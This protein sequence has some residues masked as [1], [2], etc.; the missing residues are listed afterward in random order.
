MTI[1]KIIYKKVKSGV[2]IIIFSEYNEYQRCRRKNK[3]KKFIIGIHIEIC[4][5]IWGC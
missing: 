2:K 4:E 5:R 3:Q 1:V